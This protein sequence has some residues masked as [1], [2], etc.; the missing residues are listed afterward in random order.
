M[1]MVQ[2][3]LFA[4]T[5]PPSPRPRTLLV[6]LIIAGSSCLRLVPASAFG[7][8]GGVGGGRQFAKKSISSRGCEAAVLKHPIRERERKMKMILRPIKG[9]HWHSRHKMFNIGKIPEM[10]PIH[11]SYEIGNTTVLLQSL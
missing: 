7:R 3:K 8:V 9:T 11:S 10:L 4:Q 1:V 5:S 6:L 2:G